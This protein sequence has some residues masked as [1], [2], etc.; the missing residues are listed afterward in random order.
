MEFKHS[1]LLLGANQMHT[2]GEVSCLLSRKELQIKMDK[3]TWI[4]QSGFSKVFKH[5]SSV[6]ETLTMLFSRDI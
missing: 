5:E 1:S 4:H 3:C 2:L 6:L